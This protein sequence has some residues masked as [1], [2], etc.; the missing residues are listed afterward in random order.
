MDL[1]NDDGFMTDL[2][3]DYY[4]TD[5]RSFEMRTFNFSG[6]GLFNN[7][8]TT[9]LGIGG[10]IILAIILFEIALYALDV[11]YNRTY[12]FGGSSSS[13]GYHRRKDET[14]NSE[15]YQEYPKYQD[16][17]AS[18]YR[19]LA[20]NTRLDKILEWIALGRETYEMGSE[21][22]KDMS[23]RKKIICEIYHYDLGHLT[24]RARHGMDFLDVFNYLN[25]TDDLMEQMD[26]Y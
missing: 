9:I 18:T 10:G 16:P 24:T 3:L 6:N 22:M 7:T 26:E 25:L 20:S 19:S 15:I 21:T 23:C 5:A 14:F 8:A 1:R 12:G 17:F 13:S 2:D 11:Y 4:D